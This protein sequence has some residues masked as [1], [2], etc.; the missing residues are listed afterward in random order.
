VTAPDGWVSET[1]LQELLAR[2]GETFDL[3]Y[4]SVLAIQTSPELPEH[5]GGAASHVAPLQPLLPG[6]AHCQSHIAYFAPATQ[7][8]D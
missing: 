4:M 5:N 7:K 1:R 3:D 2:R 8:L 6:E